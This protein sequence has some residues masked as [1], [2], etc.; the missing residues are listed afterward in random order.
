MPPLSARALTDSFAQRSS[1]A[2]G[3]GLLLV[4]MCLA[5]LLAQVDTSVV[6]LAVRSIGATLD[7]SV[8]GLQWVLDGYNLAYALLLLTGGLLSDLYGRR[9]LFLLGSAIFTGGSVMCAGAPD[10]AAL[11]GGRAIAGAGAALLLP[12]SLS[13]IRVE[14]S[15]ER[16]RNRALGVWGACNGLAFVVGPTVGG[17]LVDASGWR[18]VFLIAVPLGLATIGLALRAV[19]ES[20]DP[21]G[22]HFDAP[23]QL[24]GAVALGGL[25]LAGIDAA[26]DAKVAVV[27][28]LIGTV[29]CL[30]FRRTER[31]RGAEAMV[32]LDLFRSRSLVGVLT[33]TS[34][35]TFG[36]YGVLFLV[37][38][39]LQ[40]NGTLPAGAA[41]LALV[42]M[43]GLFFVLSN[44][45]GRIAENLGVRSMIG[46][47]TALI[48]SGLLVIAATGA[49]EPL[50]LAE[51]G[52]V[53]TGCGMGL[54]TGPL[55]GVAVG[56]VPAAR[57]GSAASL[58]N[59]ARMVGATLGVAVLGSAFAMAGAGAP[60]LRAA[61]LFGGT[62]Q[63]VGAFAA[64]R[65]LR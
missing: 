50:W 29:A 4:T 11:I 18:S 17:A 43:A 56:S 44:A 2:S 46:G 38:L 15:E 31:R 64:W 57:A 33:A 49:G 7:A 8:A 40:A 26:R 23:G 45:S 59:V 25:A 34:V 48:G 35:M 61:M 37:P 65:A 52:L 60:G 19:P 30:L 1:A 42:P 5:V 36:M 6:N 58:I 20:R 63:I 3:K 55:F 51:A 13:I 10:I 32:P 41:G 16:A 22:R 9:R 28:L 12:A 39:V 54:N 53:L 62:V 47:G 24:C 21:S 27:A 14:W